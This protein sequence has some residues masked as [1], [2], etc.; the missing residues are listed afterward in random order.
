[1]MQVSTVALV[2]FLTLILLLVPSDGRKGP[3]T[4]APPSSADRVQQ[5]LAG[6]MDYYWDHDPTAKDI[7]FFF[8]CGQIGGQGTLANWKKCS[9]YNQDSCL[10]CYRWWD[11]V[12]TESVATYG[13][14]TNTSN[15][16]LIA[17]TIFAHSP[18]NG[19]WDGEYS[20]TF[21]D[22]FA[23]YGIAYLRVYEWLNVS[24]V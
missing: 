14:Y 10:N 13:I 5:T 7:S 17:D 16:S 20:Y 4:Q 21:V 19:G 15:H 1:M 6:L 18:Y 3:P 12:A 9:C 8:A 23:W 2:N 22:D 11:A 24:Y